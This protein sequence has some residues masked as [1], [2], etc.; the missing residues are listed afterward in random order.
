MAEESSTPEEL[1]DTPRVKVKAINRFGI[2]TLAIVQL[3]L[4]MLSV[5]MLNFLSCTNHQRVDLTRYEDFTLSQTTKQYLESPEVKVR[6]MPIKIVAVL[7]QQSPYYLRLRAQLENY[8]RHSDNNIQLEFIDPKLDVDRL[9][10]FVNT[11]KREMTNLSEETILIDA[12]NSLPQAE[13]TEEEEQ[14]Q[15]TKHIRTIPVKDLFIEEIDRFNKKFISAWNDEAYLTSNLISAIEG[16]PRRFYFIVDK[17]RID[18]RS[19]S[20]PAWKTFQN[21]LRAQNVELQPLQISTIDKIPD[22][23]EGIAIIGPAFDF[24][25]KEIGILEDYWG[26]PS[27]A[28]FITL[29]PAAKLKNFKRFLR[30]YGISPQDNRVISVQ[31]GNTLTAARAFFAQGP[32]INKGLAHQATQLD[33][34][35]S[36]LEVLTENDRLT[37]RNITPF[38]LIQASDGWWG[39]SR[40]D[41]LNPSFNPKEDQGVIPNSPNPT[42]V[43]IAAAVVRGIEND[44]K[45]NPLTSRMIV[46]ANTDFLQPANMREELNYFINSSINW[47]VGRDALIGIDPKPV[48]R[49]KITIESSHKSLIDQFILIYLPIAS[50]LIALII[51]NSRR[52]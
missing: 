8:Q 22:D 19:N 30:D 44:D 29:D 31:N 17:A 43:H 45:T 28:V 36:G 10:D 33:G 40:Y 38:S 35:S 25:Q 7:Y 51:W 46:V 3:A 34:P 42:P 4:A 39:E 48:Y 6:Q 21:M 9:Q 47:L 18:E 2:G 16:T 41:E 13:T 37:I 14:I 12:R 49:K 20:T 5:V 23:A 52:T 1:D 11:Y 27:S 24:D 50:L 32:V 15:L 26:R